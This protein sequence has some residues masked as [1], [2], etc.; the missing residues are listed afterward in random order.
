MFEFEMYNV[1]TGETETAYGYSLTDVRERNPKYESRKWI[2]LT[3]DLIKG[4]TKMKISELKNALTKEML[5]NMIE[6]LGNTSQCTKCPLQKLCRQ[7]IDAGDDKTCHQFLE[8]IIED[9]G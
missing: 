8:E 7:E 6:T 9:E 5:V 2:C 3:L 4:E 1:N